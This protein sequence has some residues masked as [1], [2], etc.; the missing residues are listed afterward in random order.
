MYRG[1]L[2]NQCYTF[3]DTNIHAP[4]FFSMTMM[5]FYKSYWNTETY[6]RHDFHNK[7]HYLGTARLTDDYSSGFCHRQLFNQ[8]QSHTS[9]MKRTHSHTC[10]KSLKSKL[11]PIHMKIYRKTSF[12]CKTLDKIFPVNNLTPTEYFTLCVIDLAWSS[13]SP[14]RWPSHSSP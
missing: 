13:P 9:S 14:P 7:D 12:H 11:S 1:I 10:R 4:Y 8:T 6:P 5:I 3:F 2:P